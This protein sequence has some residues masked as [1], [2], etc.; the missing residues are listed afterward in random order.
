MINNRSKKLLTT[1]PLPT[2]HYPN[3]P[4]LHFSNLPNPTFQYSNIPSFQ[5]RSEVELSSIFPKEMEAIQ[6]KPV[7]SCLTQRIIPANRSVSLGPLADARE[8]HYISDR[9]YKIENPLATLKI[10]GLPSSK[11]RVVLSAY[12]NLIPGFVPL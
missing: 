1:A 11:P 8:K 12:R 3:P 4:T 2:T 10:A 9:D 7:T 5:L 6:A